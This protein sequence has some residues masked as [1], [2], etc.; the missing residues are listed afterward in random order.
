METV[1]V[2]VLPLLWPLLLLQAHA[3]EHLEGEAWI[4]FYVEPYGP[5]IRLSE[6][7]E[8]ASCAGAVFLLLPLCLAV[9][10]AH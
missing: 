3:L 10:V 8:L 6:P 7:S 9:L 4:H 1:F 2:L 5:R